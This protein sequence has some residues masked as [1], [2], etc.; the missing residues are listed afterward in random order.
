MNLLPSIASVADLFTRPL[1]I[2]HHRCVSLVGDI[3][4]TA[5]DPTSAATTSVARPT[6]VASPSDLVPLLHPNPALASALLIVLDTGASFALTPFPSDFALEVTQAPC[7]LF[8]SA[9]SLVSNSKVN[10]V[11]ANPATKKST[12]VNPHA[13]ITG[14]DAVAVDLSSSDPFDFDSNSDLSSDLSSFTKVCFDIREFGT[15]TLTFIFSPN[16]SLIK[17]FVS[18]TQVDWIHWVPLP[19]LT[20][21]ESY[22]HLFGRDY[23]QAFTLLH[24]IPIWIYSLLYFVAN[25]E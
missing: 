21:T 4:T 1:T 8:R 2:L 22:F 9:A 16:L 19:R 7:G 13:L 23:L 11:V 20:P 3:P 15:T 12:P 10:L 24:L 18:P 14:E 17:V 25:L 5:V 6:D